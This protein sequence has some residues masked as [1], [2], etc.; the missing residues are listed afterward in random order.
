MS[1]RPLEELSHDEFQGMMR[2]LP[3]DDF[4]KV[5]VTEFFG[6]LVAMDEAEVRGWN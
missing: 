1:D 4:D 2:D 3:S 5:S 6:A